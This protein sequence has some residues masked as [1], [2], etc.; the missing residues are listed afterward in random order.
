MNY[1]LIVGLLFGI[2]LAATAED[3]NLPSKVFGRDGRELSQ[4]E[5]QEFFAKLGGIGVEIAPV[6]EGV[7]VKRVLPDTPACAAGVK[8][9]DVITD[10]D[11]KP[12]HG[13]KLPEVVDRLRGPVGSE[14]AL[15][16]SRKGQAEPL[17]MK[18]VR[19][20]IRVYKERPDCEGS[21]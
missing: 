10:V 1:L 19:K 14:V 16:L 4:A 20:E 5:S 17:K 7:V 18:L 15:I 12:M 21:A 9:G 2:A 11:S 3:T 13:L 8:V 6:A